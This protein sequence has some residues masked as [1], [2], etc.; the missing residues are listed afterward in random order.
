METIGKYTYQY[1]HPA[2]TVDC[3]IFGFDGKSLRILLIERGVEP[4][5]GEWA[6]PGGFVRIDETVEEAAIR[7]LQEETNVKG[8][9]MSQLAVFSD[10]DRDPRERVVTVAFYALVKPSDYDVIGGD[11][12]ASACWFSLDN[13]PSLVFD[14][15][16][17]VKAAFAQVQRN[18]RAGNVGL[19]MFEDKFS[20]SQLYTMHSLVTQKEIDRRNFYKK[21]ISCDY[22][23]PTSEKMQETPHKPSQLFSIDRMVYDSEIRESYNLIRFD[24]NESKK[25][26]KSK[27]SKNQ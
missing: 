19:E 7:E 21:M 27:P 9:Y 4:F 23:E 22:I 8:V 18:F 15:E 14:H 24:L 6:L 26:S 2:L 17:I 13:Y 3:V 25:K 12:A 5:K 16:Q 20:I 1:P 10:V 11:D